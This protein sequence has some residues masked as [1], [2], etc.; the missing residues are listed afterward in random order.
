MSLPLSNLSCITDLIDVNDPCVADQTDVVYWFDDHGISMPTAAK[1]ADERYQTGRGLIDAKL[2]IALEDVYMHLTRNV[3][4]DCDLDKA[5]GLLCNNAQRI[6]RAVWF[7]ATALIYK[8]LSIDSKRYNDIIHYAGNEA[9]A[10]MVYFDD[11]FKGF[12]TL[13]QVNPGQYQQELNKLEPIR[14]YIEQTCCGEC[15]GSYWGITLP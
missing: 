9:L 11:S 3:T 1:I 2:R 13:E 12:T 14:T 4:P 8:E 5:T 7:R 10:Q 15:T 6:A